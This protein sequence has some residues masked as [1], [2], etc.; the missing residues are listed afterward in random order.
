M[1][2]QKNN[3]K[4]NKTFINCITSNCNVRLIN[5]NNVKKK[6][7]LTKPKII[8]NSKKVKMFSN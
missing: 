4:V 8:R 2:S 3:L 7:R 6:Y 1:L 5:K